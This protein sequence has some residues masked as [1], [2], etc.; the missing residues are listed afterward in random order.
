MKL[1]IVIFQI[2]KEAHRLGGFWDMIVKVYKGVYG[3]TLIDYFV[4]WRAYF[5]RFR[6][7]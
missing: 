4:E 6:P 3:R 7:Y 5:R 2:M 1:K